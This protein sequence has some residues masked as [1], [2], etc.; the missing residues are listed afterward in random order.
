M[1]IE[2]EKTR[3]PVLGSDREQPQKFKSATVRP[4]FAGQL[5]GAIRRCYG[6]VL[7]GLFRSAAVGAALEQA[8]E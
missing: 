5:A 7:T 6:K 8:L 2:R 1:K 3:L 4:P